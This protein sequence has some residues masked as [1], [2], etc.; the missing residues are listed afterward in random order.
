MEFMVGYDIQIEYIKGKQNKVVDALSRK[1]HL[2]SAISGYKSN[3]K[4]R[5]L[6][7]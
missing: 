6:G 1:K 4:E 2:I 5:V 3:L 7:Y